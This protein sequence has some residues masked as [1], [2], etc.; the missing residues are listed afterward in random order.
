MATKKVFIFFDKEKGQFS[1]LENCHSP[2]FRRGEKK[3]NKLPNSDKTIEGIIKKLE[4]LIVDL[5]SDGLVLVFDD[6]YRRGYC[7]R[8]EEKTE[9]RPLSEEE[10]EEVLKKIEPMM[11]NQTGPARLWALEFKGC[12]WTTKVVGGLAKIFS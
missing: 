9:N 10:R 1:F 2:K 4:A 7:R 11:Q 12:T 5:R 3:G 8:G 6:P